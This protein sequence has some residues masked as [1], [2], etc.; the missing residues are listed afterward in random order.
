MN[1][2]SL[3]ACV[4]AR[5]RVCVCVCVCQCRSGRRLVDDW[6][7]GTDV[8]GSVLDASRFHINNT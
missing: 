7:L 3:R 6:K 8:H 4:R 5:A 1:A 2:V